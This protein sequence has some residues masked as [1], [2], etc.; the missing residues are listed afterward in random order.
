MCKEGIAGGVAMFRK[1]GQQ[2]GRGV[3][4]GE[5]GTEDGVERRL[6][7]SCERGDEGLG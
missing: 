5:G 4:V 7:E 6:R 2:G 3:I 1:G